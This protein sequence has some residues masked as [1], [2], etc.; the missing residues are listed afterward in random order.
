MDTEPVIPVTTSHLATITFY[1]L[2]ALT[3]VLI[4]LYYYIERSR[5]IRLIKKLPGMYMYVNDEK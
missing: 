4:A 5:A 2:T 3:T 1:L